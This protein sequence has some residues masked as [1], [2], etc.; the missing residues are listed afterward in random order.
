M[1]AAPYVLQKGLQEWRRER[2]RK[3]KEEN[4]AETA[5][6]ASGR[7]EARTRQGAPTQPLRPECS[8]YPSAYVSFLSASSRCRHFATSKPGGGVASPAVLRGKPEVAKSVCRQKWQPFCHLEMLRQALI[9]T[10]ASGV[11]PSDI[12]TR[13]RPDSIAAFGRLTAPCRRTHWARHQS[14]EGDAANGETEA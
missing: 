13:T 5:R 1:E 11:L 12:L 14:N 4:A 6:E 7:P 8:P 9:L 3:R 2:G 10:L